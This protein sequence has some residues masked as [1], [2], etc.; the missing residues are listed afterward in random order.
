MYPTNKHD[1]DYNVFF[2]AKYATQRA[3]LLYLPTAHGH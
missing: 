3:F 2:L 1:H